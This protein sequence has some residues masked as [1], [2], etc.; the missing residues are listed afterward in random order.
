MRWHNTSIQVLFR[1]QS[2]NRVPSVWNAVW[3]VTDDLLLYQ[4]FCRTLLYCPVLAFLKSWV[5]WHNQLKLTLKI[6]IVDIFVLSCFYLFS[7]KEH[8]K[9]RNE[10]EQC[11]CLS[12]TP[13][14]WVRPVETHSEEVLGPSLNAAQALVNPQLMSLSSLEWSAGSLS[15]HKF[16]ASLQSLSFNLTSRGCRPP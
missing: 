7:H 9:Q 6:W 11:L 15:V 8:H 2:S 5:L 4:L 3:A 12:W 13:R 16:N 14:Q 1:L 10:N